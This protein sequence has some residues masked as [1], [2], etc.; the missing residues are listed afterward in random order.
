[1]TSLPEAHC[2]PTHIELWQET[3][4]WQPTDRQQLQLQS[5]YSEVITANQQLNLTR[6]TQPEEF[7]EKHLWDSLRGV[8]D[9][10]ND[11]AAL[12]VIDIGTGVGFPGLP[13]AIARPDWQLTLVDST[14]KKVGF[15]ES[16]APELGLTNVRPIVSRIEELGQNRSHRHQSDLAL[17]RA[18]AATNICAEYALPL[19]KVGGTAILYRGNWTE[20]EAT[21]LELAAA[22][23]GG[24]ISK[25][26]RFTTPISQSIRHCIWLHK[27]T[28]THPYYPRAIGMPTQK[29]L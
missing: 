25:I 7:W 12:Q 18:V 8:G 29:P 3:M 6:I 21:S 26:D 2:L 4:N 23:L 9:L 27:I 1:M 24:E 17:I 10:I 11:P 16:I 5:L 28:D 14:A 22:K 20:E 19:V 13:L 15:I